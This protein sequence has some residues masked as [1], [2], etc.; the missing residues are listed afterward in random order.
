MLG[1]DSN[2][3]ANIEAASESS[4]LGVVYRCTP[5]ALRIMDPYESGY[6]RR[7][8][9]VISEAGELLDVMT[10]IALADHVTSVP[11]SPTDEYLQRI[12][13][14]ATEQGLPE[15]YIREI[16]LSAQKRLT[17]TE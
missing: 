15:T 3:Y 9:N 11:T 14:G 6:E 16:I 10:Y 13:V 2:V 12:V 4:V 5:E 8:V 17:S 1:E 7:Q